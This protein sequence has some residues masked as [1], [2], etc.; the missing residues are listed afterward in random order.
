[1]NIT[2]V[3]FR[4][5]TINHRSC[6]CCLVLNLF[7]SFFSILF[8]CLL[9][10]VCCSQKS[11]LLWVSF[12]MHFIAFINGTDSVRYFPLLWMEM[13]G[14][15]LGQYFCKLFALVG[16]VDGPCSCTSK[17]MSHLISDWFVPIIIIAISEAGSIAIKPLIEPIALID[18]IFCFF[19]V[20]L[21]L[22]SSS[23]VNYFAYWL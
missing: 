1:M 17:W 18:A 14:W 12:K 23:S 7:Q 19:S 2:A 4:P 8:V 10:S 20:L 16:M 3:S 21:M 22:S 13:L 5:S 6:F 15:A 9:Q 11:D